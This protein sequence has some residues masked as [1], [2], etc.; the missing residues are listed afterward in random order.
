MSSQPELKRRHSALTDSEDLLTDFIA[1]QMKREIFQS[2]LSCL[3]PT[4]HRVHRN[5]RHPTSLRERPADM[6][7]WVHDRTQVTNGDEVTLLRVERDWAYVRAGNGTEG[8]VRAHYVLPVAQANEAAVLRR[9]DREGVTGLRQRPDEEDRG[10][11]I[12]IP[13]GSGVTV[14]RGEGQFTLVR[15]SEGQMGYVKSKY[16]V[17]VTSAFA[18]KESIDSLAKGQ[19]NRD[20]DKWEKAF[21]QVYGPVRAWAQL[22]YNEAHP[23]RRLMKLLGQPQKQQDKQEDESFDA[24]LEAVGKLSLARDGDQSALAE[25][26]DLLSPPSQST[27]H[28]DLRQDSTHAAADSIMN[29][30]QD[31]PH[32]AVD[33]TVDSS[34]CS[35]HVA[36]DST[37]QTTHQRP[38]TLPPL[39]QTALLGAC[40]SESIAG[41][42][43]TSME[44]DVDSFELDEAAQLF[45]DD[46]SA[47]PSTAEHQLPDIEID[48]ISGFLQDHLRQSAQH[49]NGVR[50]HSD[51]TRTWPTPKI[52]AGNARVECGT[53]TPPQWEPPRLARTM[54]EELLD[55]TQDTFDLC[56]QLPQQPAA[57]GPYGPYNPAPCIQEAEPPRPLD[58]YEGKRVLLVRGKYKGKFGFVQRKVKLKYRVQVEGVPY[59]LEFFPRTLQLVP[60]V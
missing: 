13:N 46:C 53:E 12:L 48:D 45:T 40:A 18:T 19:A 30:C 1:T 11:L 58:I 24:M 10:F 41:A 7:D 35:T 38:P 51:A 9:Y 2:E 22:R 29:S 25:V 6:N 3:E 4:K 37:V 33:S 28:V 47:V 23:T 60:G 14:L 54:T 44:E 42:S 34:H 15:T 31:S 43:C 32:A 8:Y 39:Q 59:G 27:M 16:L 52:K 26:D 50:N 17:P 21:M 57:A 49:S 56:G 20:K 36:V 55:L 5:D